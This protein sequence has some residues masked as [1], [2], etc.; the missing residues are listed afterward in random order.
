MSSTQLKRYF[1]KITELSEHDLDNICSKFELEVIKKGKFVLTQGEVC[2]FE[3]FVTKG[4]FRIFSIDKNGNERNLYIAVEN[5]WL[6]DIDSFTNGCPSELNIEALEDSEVLFISKSDKD[7]LYRDVSSTEKL[8]RI[9]SQKAVV[10]WQK[11]L[12]RNHCLTAKERYWFLLETYPDIVARLNDRQIAKYLGI[13]HEF[14]SKIK[15]LR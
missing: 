11:R 14:L 6:M 15:K 13:S 1:N 5:W 9:M 4:C 7:T 8:F 12:I 10:A 2:K 3:G